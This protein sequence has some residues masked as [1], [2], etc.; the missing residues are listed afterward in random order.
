MNI[1][2]RSNLGTTDIGILEV[3][4][5]QGLREDG[6]SVELEDRGMLGGIPNFFALDGLDST[7]GALLLRPLHGDSEDKLLGPL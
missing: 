5:R 2:A 4:S 1:H 7:P 3:K 6:T